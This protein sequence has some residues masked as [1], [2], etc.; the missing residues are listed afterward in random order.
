MSPFTE[1]GF[2]GRRSFMATYR[3]TRLPFWTASPIT[4]IELRAVNVFELAFVAIPTASRGVKVMTD[5]AT[6]VRRGR[7]SSKGGTYGG[8]EVAMSPVGQRRLWAEVKTTRPN[9]RREE[10]KI[11]KAKS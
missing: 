2:C 11:R 5:T 4:S 6:A 10:N 7:M 9:S 1:L 8:K 3:S